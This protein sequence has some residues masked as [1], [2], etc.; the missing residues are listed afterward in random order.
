MSDR[1][2][3]GSKAGGATTTEAP[4]LLDMTHAHF[5]RAERYVA[6]KRGLV[7]FF[8]KPKRSISVNFPVEMD[9]DSV[10]TFTGYRVLHNSVLGPGK[11]GIRFHPEVTEREVQALAMLMT[12]KCALVG[13]PFGGAKGG[14]MCDPRQLS[15][16]ELRRV[17]R[18]FAHELGDDIGPYT[19]IPA[20]DLYTNEQVMA[21]IY[22][23][24]AMMHPGANNRPVVTGKPLDLGGSLG[25]REATARGLVTVTET[26]LANAGLPGLDRLEGARVAIQGFGNVGAIA[27]EIFARKGALV[28]ALADSRTGIRDP[29]GIDIKKALAHKKETGRLEGL[30]GTETLGSDDILFADCDILVPAALQN[31]IRS[32]NAHE[33]RAR[34]VVE[35]ANGPITPEADDIL[36]AR[37]IAVLPDILANSGGVIVSYYE[38]VQNLHMEEWPLDEVNRKLDD[39]LHRTVAA[40]IAKAR[41]LSA[42]SKEQDDKTLHDLHLR[43]AAFAIGL[44]RL[45][46][47]T[48]ERGIWP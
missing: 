6:T 44:E 18:R 10:R 19:D 28:V 36:M 29:R 11:G 31:V 2:A 37:D 22:D 48:L 20:P 47:A 14:V 42:L 9:D 26:F 1:A 46:K 34:L 17:T 5:H 8:L 15:E 3:G 30:E 23:T 43:T 21:W 24:Y 41:E 12:L 33:V 45:V 35:G 38:W 13:M 4:D 40:V 7:D 16:R 32:D 27:A 25:R 39:R